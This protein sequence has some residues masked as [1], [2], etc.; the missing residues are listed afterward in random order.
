MNRAFANFRSFC[1]TNA[2]L[3]IKNEILVQLN[4]VISKQAD[5]SRIGE[6]LSMIKNI[7]RNLELVNFTTNSLV[8]F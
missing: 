3:E 5:L 8:F 1:Y 4:V 6:E 2:N 7:S